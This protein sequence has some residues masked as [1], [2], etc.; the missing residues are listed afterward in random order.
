MSSSLLK[1]CHLK[2]ASRAGPPANQAGQL[3]RRYSQNL[4]PSRMQLTE[5]VQL[6]HGS[7]EQGVVLRSGSE[8]VKEWLS[9][10]RVKA[11]PVLSD[12]F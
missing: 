8:P 6:G 2:S 12:A 10:C 1:R 3:R 7:A 4:Q 11:V 9:A 5:V